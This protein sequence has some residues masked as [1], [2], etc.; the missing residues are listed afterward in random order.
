MMLAIHMAE[1]FV[2]GVIGHDALKAGYLMWTRE[3][4]KKT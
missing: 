1:A 2:L 3:H 4:G